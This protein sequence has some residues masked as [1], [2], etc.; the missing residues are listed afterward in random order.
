[1]LCA[2]TCAGS[3]GRVLLDAGEGGSVGVESWQLALGAA[4]TLVALWYVGRLAKRALDD[5]EDAE[6]A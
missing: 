1:M 3:Y 5:V 4:V 2:L 6:Q